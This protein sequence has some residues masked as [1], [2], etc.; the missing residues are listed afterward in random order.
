MSLEERI[1][2][3]VGR[4]LD[5]M[6]AR[7]E[8]DVRAATEAVEACV[9]AELGASLVDVPGGSR[10]AESGGL[11]R[12]LDAI[13]GLDGATSLTEVL[14]GLAHAARRESARAALV[15]LRGD[16]VQGWKLSGFGAIDAR[17]KALDLGLAEAGIIGI[18]GRNGRPATTREDG[19]GP[20]FAELPADGFALA[21]PVVVGGRSV[22]VVYSDMAGSNVEREAV[23][24]SGWSERTEILARHAGRCLEALTTQRAAQAPRFW[25]P[26][27]RTLAS[28]PRGEAREPGA[29]QATSS[30]EPGVPA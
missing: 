8:A 5:G 4:A 1:S 26:S 10:E 22:A 7:V 17:P 14:D 24:S 6:R 27:S 2:Q 9:R 28:T 30:V 3:S 11:V 25:V 16:R 29:P 19:A 21:V 20:A 12:L 23:V 18:A 13:R 15:V